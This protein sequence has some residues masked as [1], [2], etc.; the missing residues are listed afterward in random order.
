[1]FSNGLT[2]SNLSNEDN[3]TSPLVS[4]LHGLKLAV[5]LLK[6]INKGLNERQISEFLDNNQKPV[7]Q[8]FDFLKRNTWIESKSGKFVVSEKGITWLNRYENG[9]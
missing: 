1:M 2:K 3:S 4:K 8:W 5:Y 7:E 9:W 6:C